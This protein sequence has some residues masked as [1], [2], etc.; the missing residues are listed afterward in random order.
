MEG[1]RSLMGQLNA[2]IAGAIAGNE[3]WRFVA[4]LVIIVGGFSLLE[5]LWR[6]AN[7]WV[8]D[9]MDKKQYRKWLP[10][11]SGFLPAARVAAAAVLLRLSE[12]PLFLPERLLALLHGLEA[13]LLALAL[14]IFLFQCI[15]L[16]DLVS[17]IL[18]GRYRRKFTE[19]ILKGLKGILRI[20]GVLLTAAAFIYT[21][22]SILPAWL[23]ESSAWRYL[24][25]MFVV[26]ILFLGGRFFNSF[27]QT[28]T[29]ALKD[30]TERAR[31]RL[32]MQASLWPVRLL[33]AMIIIFAVQEILVLSPGAERIAEI[34]AESLGVL[35]VVVFLYKLLDLV[36]YEL[37]RFVKREDN[38]Y[39]MNLVQFV[40]I[41]A[42][43]L[44]VV[45]G[46][47]FLMKTV[48][49][50]P[51]TTLLAG[52]GIGGLAVALAAQDTLKNLFGSFMLMIDKPFAVGDWVKVE[53]T[54]AIVEEIGFRCTRLRSFWGNLISI[55]NEKMASMSIENVQRRPYIRRWM[56]LTITYDT[57]PKKV[58]RAVAIVK[59]IL[60][61]RPELDPAYP[62]RVH[63][64]NFNDASLN[65]L[66]VYWYRINN[67]W[68]S[69]VFNEKIN[70]EV[71][72]AFNEEG[73]EF[74]FPTTTTYLAH[75]ER[76]PLTFTLAGSPGVLPEGT[77]T[78]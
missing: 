78:N 33:L 20:A 73:I 38:D 15:R 1:F 8:E 65:I 45:F 27:L 77:R 59:D 42:K 12:V 3:V 24:S 32:V 52:L 61:S 75:D 29:T 53:G 2:L 72:R 41:A 30:S 23:V 40:R 11:L 49:G 66:V 46:V 48:T 76:R 51:M 19:D 4:S 69:M 43:V 35:V 5:V 37:I 26:L 22:K 55:P 9:V 31:L 63:F 62:P 56:N 18:P 71:L 10:H 47:V 36:D 7:R 54:D 58:E 34:L 6:R 50:K 21:Q 28:V 16:L 39:D 60:S 14:M 67:Y 70:F 64:N 25:L 44:I 13:F 17:I 68:E 74:A 57:P